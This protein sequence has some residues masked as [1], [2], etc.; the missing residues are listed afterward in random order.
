MLLICRYP[1]HFHFAKK[2]AEAIRRLSE[3]LGRMFQPPQFI[4]RQLCVHWPKRQGNPP[5]TKH[6]AAANQRGVTGAA[7]RV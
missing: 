6:E 1:N 5:N 3:R 7:I 4:G 2:S